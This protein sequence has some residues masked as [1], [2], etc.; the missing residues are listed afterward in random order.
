M[1]KKKT[2]IIATSDLHVGHTP[3]EDIIA[4]VQ[5]IKQVI[6]KQVLEVSTLLVLGDV[7]ESLAAIETVLGTLHDLAPVR[8]FLPRNHDLFDTEMIG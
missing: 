3:I 1:K 2:V 5:E 4:M 6:E 7:G 8:I